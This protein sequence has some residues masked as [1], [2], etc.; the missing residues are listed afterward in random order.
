[1][2]FEARVGFIIVFLVIWAVIGTVPW[3]MAAIRLK[4]RG[5]L[6][7]L[8]LVVLSA[9]LAGILVPLA[10]ARDVTGFWLSLVTALIG[11][12]AAAAG[13]AALVPKLVQQ[14]PGRRTVLKG[15]RQER[16][17]GSEDRGAP[18]DP[19][20]PQD[21]REGSQDERGGSQDQRGRS[22]D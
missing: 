17:G 9:V 6:L 7:L 8:P 13:G 10:G 5:A 2:T 21:E 22:Q 14:N 4:G 20:I 1:M 12:M 16:R 19:S 18:L 11:A 3:A 15:G